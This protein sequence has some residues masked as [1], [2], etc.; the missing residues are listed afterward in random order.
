MIS[1]QIVLLLGRVLVAAEQN[2]PVA[3]QRAVCPAPGSMRQV[4]GTCHDAESRFLP[5]YVFKS[6][7]C[8]AAGRKAFLGNTYRDL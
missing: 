1:F 5:F 7:S 2:P 6:P 8:E 3:G 4:S